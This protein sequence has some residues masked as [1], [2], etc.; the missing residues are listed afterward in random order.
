MLN[1][2]IRYKTYL[3]ILSEELIPAMG[4]TEPIAIAYASAKA[5]SVLGILP[6][7]VL[8]EV[9]GNVIKNVKSVVVP[10]TGGLRG[11]PAAAAA[12]IVAGDAE[13]ELEVLS[14][15]TDEQ[16]KEITDFLN[17]AEIEVRHAET[18]QV[19]DIMITVWSG[20]D[21]AYVRLA[22]RHTNIVCIR[23]NGG[24]ILEKDIVSENVTT[25]DRNLLDIRH[26]VEFADS[27]DPADVRDLLDRQIDYNMAIAEEGLRNDYGANIGKVLLYEHEHV[28]SRKMRAYAAAGSDAR[29]NGCEMP[30]IIN[31]GS[32]NQGLTTSVPVIVYAKEMGHS[33]EELLRALCIANLVTIHLKTGIGCLSAYCGV[34]SAGCGAASGVAWLQGGR[35]DMIAH[36]IVNALAMD[37]GIICDGAKASCAAKISS[38]IDAAF[39]GLRMYQ[40]GNQFY[41]GD[42]IVKKGVENTIETVARLA[43]DGMHYTDKEIIKLMMES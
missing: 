8:I 23:K 38:A 20:S 17:K 21:S 29:M 7:R 40:Q 4:C 41:G 19:F 33:H 25:A 37:S 13:K 39:L 42:G 3:D 28:L 5:R 22:Q 12:G 6:E 14:C 18:D 35:F 43:R 31:S 26:I 27:V 1:T 36:T 34:V 10:H 32:G 16:L 24:T 15:V 9:S 11:I 30:V 2:D